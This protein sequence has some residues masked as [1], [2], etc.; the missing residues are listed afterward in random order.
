MNPRYGGFLGIEKKFLDTSKAPS[1]LPV[2]TLASS[3][4]DPFGDNLTPIA[5][6]DGPS[7][8]DGKQVCIKSIHL[9]GKIIGLSYTN[10]LAIPMQ[11][12]GF[13]MA[14]VQDNQTNGAAVD[15]NVVFVNAGGADTSQSP[16]INLEWSSRFKIIKSMRGVIA[17]VEAWYVAAAQY[18]G[19]GGEI[20]FDWY[21][22]MN[23]I[24]NWVPSD[25][26]GV[27]A[28]IKDKS[29]HLYAGAGNSNVQLQVA[30]NCRVRFV[31]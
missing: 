13:W 7:N 27:I 31:G 10:T 6:G 14:L 18:G 21:I 22:P 8:R 16:M 19:S 3:R 30:Y 25:I 24:Q 20:L 9:K 15:G 23:E 4:H 28:N 11:S 17:P 12:T 1:N 5:A 26:N 2:G 29:W